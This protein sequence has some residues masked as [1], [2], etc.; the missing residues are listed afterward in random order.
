MALIQT[1]QMLP[2]FHLS[3]YNL[4]ILS[5]LIQEYMYQQKTQE[6]LHFIKMD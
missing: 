5:F 6:N 4:T 3:F 2:A 1:L